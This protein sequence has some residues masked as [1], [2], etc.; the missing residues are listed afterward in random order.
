[1]FDVQTIGIKELHVK[2]KFISEK[3]AKG[4]EFIVIKN[5]KPIFKIVPYHLP[6]KLKNKKFNFLEEF[7]NAQ[8]R[9]KDKNLSKNIDKILYS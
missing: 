2:M 5:S 3:A 8:F 6:K 7:K 1:M 9:A 4:Q